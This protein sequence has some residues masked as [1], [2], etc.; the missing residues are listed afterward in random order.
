MEQYMTNDEVLQELRH[1]RFELEAIIAKLD[2]Y[3]PIFPTE[4]SKC[5]PPYLDCPKPSI[6]YEVK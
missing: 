5:Y 2:T 3:D 4:V 1:L 6:D